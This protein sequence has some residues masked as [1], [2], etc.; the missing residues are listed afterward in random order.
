ML[1]SIKHLDNRSPQVMGM[2]GANFGSGKVGS[3]N[4]SS[5]G[6]SVFSG[7]GQKSGNQ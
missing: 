4:G 1:P 6:G 7:V 3:N 5:S 2:S